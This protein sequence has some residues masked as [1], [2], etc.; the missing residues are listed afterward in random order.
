MTEKPAAK[1]AAN[2]ENKDDAGA[3]Q[4]QQSFDEAAEKGYFG[5]S[6]DDT[7][8]ENYSLETGPDAPTPE[9]TE[10]DEWAKEHAKQKNR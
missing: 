10:R 5:H 3:D 1:K 7:P 4:V 2:S 9:T 6:P 8:R